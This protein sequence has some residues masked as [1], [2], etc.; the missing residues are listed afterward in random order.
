MYPLRVKYPSTQPKHETRRIQ[1]NKPQ[2]FAIKAIIMLVGSRQAHHEAVITTLSD[3]IV[4]IKN[5]SSLFRHKVKYLR[6][7]LRTCKIFISKNYY[8]FSYICIY[9]YISNLSMP[10]TYMSEFE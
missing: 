6:V 1:T 4:G 3:K 10:V 2:T 7:Y 5:E 9:I 8:L